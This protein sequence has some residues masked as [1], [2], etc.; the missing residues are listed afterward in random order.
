METTLLKLPTGT[1]LEPEI[2]EIEAAA[3]DERIR[4]IIMER[5][6]A[7]NAPDAVFVVHEDV[8]TASRARLMAKLRQQGVRVWFDEWEIQP[9]D[10]IFSKLEYGLENTR[11]L[12]L[13]MS[14][15]SF[16]S[17][18]ATLE[19]QTVRFRDPLNKDR[20]FIPIYTS[21]VVNRK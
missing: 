6:A 7:A 16:A 15:A 11:L 20:R 21:I 8:F 19:S 10:S 9:G 3:H 4:Q 5:I 18:W 2:E 1:V 14:A 17:D 12:L 13:F